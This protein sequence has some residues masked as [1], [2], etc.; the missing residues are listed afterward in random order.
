MTMNPNTNALKHTWT[1]THTHTLLKLSLKT[2]IGKLPQRVEAVP[3]VKG[4]HTQY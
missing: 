2:T 1:H 3:K 4:G